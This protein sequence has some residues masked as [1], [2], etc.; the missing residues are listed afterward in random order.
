MRRAFGANGIKRSLTLDPRTPNGRRSSTEV[1]RLRGAN[2]QLSTDLA[3]A[4]A[5]CVE[6]DL[7]LQAALRS[8][9]TDASAAAAREEV[10]RTEAEQARTRADTMSQSLAEVSQP[11]IL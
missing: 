6:L 8:K 4:K 3:E 5:K 1:E 7:R 9:E 2:G 10:L 11:F